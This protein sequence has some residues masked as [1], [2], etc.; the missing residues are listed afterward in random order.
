[1]LPFMDFNWFFSNAL[2]S[3][4]GMEYNPVL[5]SHEYGSGGILTA[6]KLIYE[7]P[8]SS[9]FRACV[10]QFKDQNIELSPFFE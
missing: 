3:C 5:A 6:F 2:L 8:K 9:E 7:V 1:M 10:V 4:A